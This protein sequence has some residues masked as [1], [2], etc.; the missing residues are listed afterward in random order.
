MSGLLCQGKGFF[1]ALPNWVLFIYS[2]NQVSSALFPGFL[3]FHLCK[4][5]HCLNL[6][7]EIYSVASW[8]EVRVAD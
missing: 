2:E 5:L 4:D 1:R 6:K 7:T 3:F 8:C